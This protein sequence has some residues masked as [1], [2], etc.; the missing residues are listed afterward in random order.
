MHFKLRDFTIC[1]LFLLQLNFIVLAKLTAC[2]PLNNGNTTYT[3]YGEQWIY[4]D[5]PFELLAGKHGKH[6]YQSAFVYEDYSFCKPSFHAPTK[7][8]KDT[9]A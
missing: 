7:R 5:L 3:Q 6:V 9:Y 4:T 2:L 1:A 8:N